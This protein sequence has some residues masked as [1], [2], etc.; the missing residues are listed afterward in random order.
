MKSVRTT[1]VE[2]PQTTLNNRGTRW[3]NWLRHFAT[4]RKVAGSIPDS[5]IGIFIDI[6]LPVAL[7]P[8]GRHNL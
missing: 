4:S 6:I 2:F 8:C 5:I 3:R 7:W 1:E